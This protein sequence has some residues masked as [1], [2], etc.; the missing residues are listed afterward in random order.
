MYTKWEN[1][2]HIGLSQHEIALSQTAE[3]YLWCA[4]IEGLLSEMAVRK[5]Y[6]QV[7]IFTAY[8][9]FYTSVR[10]LSSLKQNL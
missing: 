7:Y 5:I 4:I 3:M 8:F 9:A 2:I 10:E 6:I 1:D